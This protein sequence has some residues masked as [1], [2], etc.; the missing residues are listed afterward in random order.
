[1][2]HIPVPSVATP[3]MLPP[4]A[5]RIDLA[6]ILYIHMTPYIAANQK[7]ALDHCDIS[8]QFLDLIKTSSLALQSET[9][10]L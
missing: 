9:L 6:K 3:S 5:P 1:M 4:H 7:S 8:N 2:A 10:L